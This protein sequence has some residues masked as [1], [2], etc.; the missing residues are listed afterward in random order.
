MSPIN[1]VK[2]LLPWLLATGDDDGTVKLW[3]PRRSE[4]VR[5]YSHHIDYITDFLWLDDTKHLAASSG[6]GTLSVIDVRSKSAG[7]FAESED[8]DD[9]LLSLVA[10][11]GSTKVVVGTQTGMLSVFNR[12]SGWGDCVDRLPGH[13]QSVDALCALPESLPGTDC[14]STILSGSSDGLVRAVQIFPTE[15]LGV[16]ADHGEWP[17]ERIAVGE[18]MTTL[19]LE[20]VKDVKELGKW[21]LGSIGHDESLKLTALQPFFEASDESDGDA[22]EA[23]SDSDGVSG[24]DSDQ[25]LSRKRKLKGPLDIPQQIKKSRGSEA[26][27]AFGFFDDLQ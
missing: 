11:K 6:D 19:S 22:S 14:A 3:D 10:I 27:E 2:H 25:Q 9:E 13:P 16:V 7:P 15:L 8:Q 5:T 23:A 20:A 18:G 17:V 12:K 21:W 24:V 4:C 26:A 1:R